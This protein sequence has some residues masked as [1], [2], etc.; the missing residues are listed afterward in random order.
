MPLKMFRIQIYRTLKINESDIKKLSSENYEWKTE[1][2]WYKIND[3]GNIFKVELI[4]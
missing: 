4:L 3:H 1:K 2:S